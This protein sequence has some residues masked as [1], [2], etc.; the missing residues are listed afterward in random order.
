MNH[1]V[2]FSICHAE[3]FLM[4]KYVSFWEQNAHLEEEGKVGGKPVFK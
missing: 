2:I 4:E 1:S 3:K